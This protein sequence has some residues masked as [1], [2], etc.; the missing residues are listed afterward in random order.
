MRP[1]CREHIQHLSVVR[2]C[3]TD[4]VGRQERKPQTLRDRDSG[5]VASFLF[6]IA[7]TLELDINAFPA[8]STECFTGLRFIAQVATHPQCSVITHY[9]AA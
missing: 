8:N 2:L 3:I 6:A 5:F 4:A 9:N 1:D 7:M